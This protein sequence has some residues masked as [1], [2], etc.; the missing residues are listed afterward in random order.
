MG[1]KVGNL[2]RKK[3]RGINCLVGWKRMDTVS[4]WGRL[5]S[6]PFHGLRPV[7]LP[8]PETSLIFLLCVGCASDCHGFSKGGAEQSG[9]QP[10]TAGTY[11]RGG[12]CSAHIK[13]QLSQNLGLGNTRITTTHPNGLT[14]P[15]HVHAPLGHGNDSM[16]INHC[17]GCLKP[18]R[19]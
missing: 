10:S 6:V 2:A 1:Q 8:S 19:R 15:C 14:H 13:H 17:S 4:C 5:N 7:V 12:C 9:R 3:G 18:V 11:G 16:K